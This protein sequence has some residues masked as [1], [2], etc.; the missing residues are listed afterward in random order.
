[1]KK[2]NKILLISLISLTI[3]LFIFPA[4]AQTSKI[5]DLKAIQ[6]A[7]IEKGANWVA[8]ETSMS[9]LSPNERVCGLIITDFEYIQPQAEYDPSGD[10]VLPSR[11]DWRSYDGH[12]W[13]TSVK[14][15]GYCGSCWAFAP[16]ASFESRMKIITDNWQQNPNYS[17]QFLVS[18]SDAGSC[19]GGWESLAQDYMQT[20]GVCDEACFPYVADDV[21]CDPCADWDSRLAQISSWRWVGGSWRSI[22][23]RKIKE[24]L[25]FGPVT[26]AMEVYTDFLAYS[27]G[28]YEHTWGDFQGYHAISIIGWDQT[29]QP[30]CWI[31][32]NSWGTDWGERGF[33]RIEMGVN[34]C[35]IEQ[36]TSS[37]IPNTLPAID[38]TGTIEETAANGATPITMSFT[39]I[40]NGGAVD[41]WLWD[42]GDGKTSTKMNPIHTYLSTGS[43]TVSLI[44]TGPEGSDT[45][46]KSNFIQTSSADGPDLTTG[47]WNDFFIFFS[48]RSVYCKFETS[49]IGNQDADRFDVG[50]Y[51]SEDGTTL[52]KLLKK[53]T[54]RRGLGAGK[55]EKYGFYYFSIT[56]L[57]GKYIIAVVDSDNQINETDKTNN[58]IVQE[59]K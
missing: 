38:F 6:Q 52:G 12:N 58:K 19:D 10:G 43:Y 31:C 57:S 24:A 37:L 36:Q 20:T 26:T 53:T 21:P 17:E 45:E 28:I 14:D 30:A 32:K 18:C 5:A 4:H 34:E 40:Y 46:I 47:K 44:A 51:L 50:F 56:P 35:A 9:V 13:V 49:N 29:T 11:L 41:N 42:F 33:F 7:I 8:G 55:S 2:I 59:I 22:D 48:G 27:G 25:E 1:M 39:A 3:C 54:L 15:Q 16:I 23:V